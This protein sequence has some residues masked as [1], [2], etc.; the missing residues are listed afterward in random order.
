M[1][2]LLPSNAIFSPSVARLAAS[3][4]RD[5][6]FIDT[7]LS[8]KFR[9][10]LSRPAPPFERTPET[11]AALLSLAALVDAADDARA[12]LST[13]AAPPPS[14][15]IDAFAAALH[16]ALTPDAAAAL[17]VLA[18]AATATHTAPATPLGIGC[19]VAALHA[20]ACE[21]EQMAARVATLQAY[22]SDEALPQAAALVNDLDEDDALRPPED[23]ARLN[24]EAQRR[25]KGAMGRMPELKERVAAVERGVDV[26]AGVSLEEIIQAEEEYLAA[27]V[28]KKELDAQVAM[29]QGM[30][31][32]VNVARE[33]LD[34]L[35]AELERK[36]KERDAIFENLVQKETPRHSRR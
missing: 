4:A 30:P 12:L 7:W 31:T 32:D 22:L 33:E 13:A 20:Q 2:H 35:R 21:T 23:L 16:D 5:W 36:T 25:I 18:A 34:N 14:S 3:T 28:V 10:V 15:P 8:T 26:G 17:D 24:L 1:S 9:S 6:S 29:F 27:L 11:L 19:A